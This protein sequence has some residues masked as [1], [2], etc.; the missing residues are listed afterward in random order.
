MVVPVL[1]HEMKA[2]WGYFTLS[3]KQLPVLCVCVEVTIGQ[4][5][6]LECRVRAHD[7]WLGFGLQFT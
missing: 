7:L 6:D 3:R 2:H 5:N 4:D 1:P